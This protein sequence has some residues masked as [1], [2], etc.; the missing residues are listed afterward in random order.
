MFKRFLLLIASGLI[1]LMLTLTTA[2]AATS[3]TTP[4]PPSGPAVFKVILR[5]S[6]GKLMS[7]VE[8]DVISYDWGLKMGEPYAAIAKGETDK[9]GSVSFDDSDWPFAGYYFRFTKTDHTEPA[10]TF[11]LPPDQNQFQGFP[12]ADA[13]GLTDTEYFYIGGDGL[14]YVD[15]SS[16]KADP[17]TQNNPRAGLAM[18]GITPQNGKDFL[19]TARAAT[20]TAFAGGIP[21]ATPP[22]AHAFTGVAPALTVTPQADIQAA[23]AAQANSTSPTG[24]A[25]APNPTPS[26]LT[27]EPSQVIYKDSGAK[28]ST[29]ANITSFL[30][31][32]IFALC[33]VIFWTKRHQVYTWLGIE[34]SP[35]NPHKLPRS[36]RKLKKKIEQYEKTLARA[37]EMGLL[38]KADEAA[39]PTAK[40]DSK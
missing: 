28:N 21:T 11:F 5:D 2:Y 23:A 14:A 8:C 33:L 32:V 30:V 29:A 40:T 1:A 13:G 19:A 10:G 38:P 6:Y 39:A 31:A 3:N 24:G 36:K 25:A 18:P 22:P 26:N 9:N 15:L 20:A 27:S 16:G 7:G 37:R 17:N 34:A 12:A 4:T 35:K